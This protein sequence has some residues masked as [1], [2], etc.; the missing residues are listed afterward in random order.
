MHCNAVSGTMQ[1]TREWM[2]FIKIRMWIGKGQGRGRKGLKWR[3]G[4]G[5]WAVKVS[6][7]PTVGGVE[8]RGAIDVVARLEDAH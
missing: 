5:V 7:K 4:L 3:A 2:H 8:L 6:R 1:R